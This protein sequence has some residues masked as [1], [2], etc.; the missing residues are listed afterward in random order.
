MRGYGYKRYNMTMA[1]QSQVKPW[2][3]IGA[4][5]AFMHGYRNNPVT[6]PWTVSSLP[7]SQRSYLQTVGGRR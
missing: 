6:V 7:H 4:N 1:V 3:K 5:T 2:L